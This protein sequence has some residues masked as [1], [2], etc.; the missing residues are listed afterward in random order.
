M[1]ESFRNMGTVLMDAG[2]LYIKKTLVNLELICH[3]SIIWP[4]RCS[5]RILHNGSRAMAEA[6]IEIKVGAFSFTGEGTEKWLSGELDKLIAKLPELVEIAPP[7]SPGDDA[8]AGGTGKKN[9]KLGTLANFLK[10]KSAT[11]N[12]VKKFLATAVWLHGTTGKDRI[13]TGE[14]KKALQKANQPKITNPSD[15]LNQ[16]VGKGHAEK[17]GGGFFVTDPGRTSLGL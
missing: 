6:R 3:W 10:E 1:A 13:T 9:G 4:Y 7:E 14:V 16:N 5:W 8:G 2:G 15:A 12:Q 11:N 17:D